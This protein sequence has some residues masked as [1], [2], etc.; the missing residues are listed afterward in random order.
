MTSIRYCPVLKP[1]VAPE[2][3][4]VAA[5][6]M[7]G[8]RDLGAILD[9]L[10]AGFGLEAAA[11]GRHWLERAAQ[12]NLLDYQVQS[13]YGNIAR[14]CPL[15]GGFQLRNRLP[16]SRLSRF[17]YL[18][19]EANTVL[20]ESPAVGARIILHPEGAELLPSVLTGTAVSPLL[21]LLGETGFLE[22]PEDDALPA[23]YW[24]FHDLLFH[25]AARLGSGRASGATWRFA[26]R[27]ESPPA[28][29]APM[30][31]RVTVLTGPREFSGDAPF[32]LVVE[33]RRSVRDPGPQPI[34][35]EQLGE[36]LHRSVAI[37]KRLQGGPQE[38]LLRPYPSGGAIHELEYYIAVRE[39]AGL[40]PGLYHY[41]AEQ[42][43]LYQL[44]ATAQQVQPLFALAQ[45]SWGGAHAAPQLFFTL[46]VRL[47]RLAWKYQSMA[48]RVSMIN[49]G[50][51]IQTMYLAA[52]AMGLAPCGVGNGDPRMFQALTGIDPMEESSIAEFALS[53]APSENR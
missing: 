51:A 2:S 21:R 11:Q 18:R 26:D 46:A 29:K 5:A 33:A 15:G 42:H 49:A 3:V 40:E 44:P 36:F 30:G 50:A 24:E 25:R 53:A 38:L 10:I 41:H 6:W 39:C 7:D 28:V 37:R 48:Y 17:A 45:G 14:V 35:V 19:R 34:T 52:T 32:Q 8:V 43:A 4:P 9:Q 47:P 20:L 12:A 27:A 23:A 1:G 22:A 13:L 31:S 16:G